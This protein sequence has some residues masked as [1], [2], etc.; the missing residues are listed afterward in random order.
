[1]P[2][3]ILPPQLTNQI[4]AGEVV[5]RPASVVKELV[6]NSLDAGATDIQIDI[7]QGGAQLIRV[8]DN[9]VG[10]AKDELALALARHATSK[11][12]NLDDLEHILSFGFRGEA[13]ASIS[14]VSRLTLTSRTAEQSAAWQVY[15]EGRDMLATIKPAAHPVGSTV[16]VASLF[17]NTPA[18]RKFMRTEKTEFSH[19]DEVIRRIALVK[20]N[21]SFTLSHN[22]KTIRQYPKAQSEAQKRKRLSQI[23]GAEF[24]QHALEIN[25]Q[26][27]DMHLY[28]WVA[29]TQFLR[30]QNDLNYSYVNGRMMRDKTILHAI[31]QAY[32]EHLDSQLYPAFVLFLD[33]DPRLVD[34]NVHPAKHEV[35]FHQVRLVHDFIYQGVKE[36]LNQAEQ[37][38][39][40]APTATPNRAAA[41][42]NSFTPRTYRPN[43]QRGVSLQ[44]RALYQQLLSTP[45]VQEPQE[46]YAPK[47]QCAVETEPVTTPEPKSAVS[48]ASS[49]L[50]LLTLLSDSQLLLLQRQR[51]VFVCQATALGACAFRLDL[52]HNVERHALLIPLV[53]RLDNQQLTHWHAQEP[54]FTAL[55]FEVSVYSQG[56]SHR[57]TIT[58]VPNPL[59]THN[60]QACMLSAL[61]AKHTTQADMLQALCRPISHK[62]TS[63]ADAS[64]ALNCVERY[65][66]AAL[67]ALLMPLDL[68][69][70]QDAP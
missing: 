7:E 11:I 66:A 36:A 42:E 59:R 44:E 53:L 46:Q 24:V 39:L 10:I 64:Q 63:L 38:P 23:C 18:R 56:N 50:R 37:L 9:G 65:D 69:Q 17:Y 31:R 41:G 1:M 14:S 5:E 51:H 47:L 6:E 28:G 29:D 70:F 4:A 8:R 45:M 32:G 22:G 60:L 68:S 2:I 15:V 55:G 26:H 54:F 58:A 61:T 27:N 13:L 62:M 19:I 67:T 33:L 35:R 52:Q 57:L 3:Q 21:T 25:W 16:E 30:S 43:T 49:H 48:V 20:N 34:V 12:S 40:N